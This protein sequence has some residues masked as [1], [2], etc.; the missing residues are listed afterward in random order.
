M[1][2]FKTVRGMRDFLPE[3]TL[4]MKIIEK[5]ARRTAQLYGYSEVIT[6][7]LESYELLTSKIGEEIRSRMYAFK[8]LGGRNVALRPEFTASIA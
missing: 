5:K 8:D 6:P 7:I 4:K 3:S 2:A 1:P